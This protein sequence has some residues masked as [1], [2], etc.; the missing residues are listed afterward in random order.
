[1]SRGVGSASHSA[2]VRS[3]AYFQLS[4]GCD[5]EVGLTA[6]AVYLSLWLL[7]KHDCSHHLVGAVSQ[8][9]EGF[10]EA[11]SSRL[12]AS[13]WYPSYSFRAMR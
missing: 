10:G 1:M 8:Q 5:V 6:G 4:C 9:T 7:I 3:G 2:C 11:S 13:C 12:A